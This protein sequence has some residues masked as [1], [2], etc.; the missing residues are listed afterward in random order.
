MIRLAR[1]CRDRTPAVKLTSPHATWEC[2]GAGIMA[3]R[4]W[5][6][7]RERDTTRDERTTAMRAA[8]FAAPFI[9]ARVKAMPH[10]DALAAEAERVG[11]PRDYRNDLYVHDLR[12]LDA[13]DPSVP[14]VWVL[15]ECGTCL[16]T[17]EDLNRFGRSHGMHLSPASAADAF[18]VERCRFYTW[19]GKHLTH[20]RT[21]ETC[22]EAAR[23]L[24]ARWRREQEKR[25]A[26]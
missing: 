12:Q 4:D 21:P 2:L 10:F 19:D 3:T 5:C 15:R 9:T 23:E 8:Y 7:D 16:N 17:A 20:H 22:A 1:D 6:Y 18:G 26:S 24:G 13:T 25:R 14:F 11:W